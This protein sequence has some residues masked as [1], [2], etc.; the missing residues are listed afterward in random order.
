VHSRITFYVYAEI[1]QV[2]GAAAYPA[3]PE[4]A[5]AQESLIVIYGKG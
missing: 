3:P 1:G 4:F 2:N 5:T